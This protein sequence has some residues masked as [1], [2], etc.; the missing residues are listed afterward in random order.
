MHGLM[1]GAKKVG[2][3]FSAAAR[4]PEPTM[5]LRAFKLGADRLYG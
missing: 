2:I 1:S 3:T 5:I 4:L